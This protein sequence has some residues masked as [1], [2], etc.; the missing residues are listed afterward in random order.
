MKIT[1]LTAAGIQSFIKGGRDIN[2]QGRHVYPMEV[3]SQVERR[4]N[5]FRWQICD[6]RV[7]VTFYKHNAAHA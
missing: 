3:A 6:W 4:I 1:G 5:V 2:I 7:Y